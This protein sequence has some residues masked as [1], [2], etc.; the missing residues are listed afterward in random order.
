LLLHYGKEIFPKKF[1]KYFC[2]AEN[3]YEL[4]LN[5]VINFF[6]TLFSK[7]NIM[8]EIKFSCLKQVLFLQSLQIATPLLVP[9]NVIWITNY[10]LSAQ[11]IFLIYHVSFVHASKNY[12]P[13]FKLYFM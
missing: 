8:Y 10:I 11:I 5:Y 3:T 9:N 12:F 1:K 2:R 4:S 6:Q 7:D 13:I